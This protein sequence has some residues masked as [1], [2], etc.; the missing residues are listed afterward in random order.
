M[1][2]CLECLVFSHRGT[3]GAGAPPGARPTA[4]TFAPCANCG[5][6]A[7][8]HAA[9]RRPG[10]SI[11][12]QHLTRVSSRRRPGRRRPHPFPTPHPPSMF[13]RRRPCVGGSSSSSG[14]PV[15]RHP[16][17]PQPKPLPHHTALNPTPPFS[18][19]DHSRRLRR[20][21][22]ARARAPICRHCLL[23]W[24]VVSQATLRARGRHS[25]PNRYSRF[26]RVHLALPSP[27]LS[28]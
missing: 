28:M 11:I 26:I 27:P 9:A 8:M 5:S 25:E 10:P 7:R 21:A 6:D 22:R 24:R 1:H 18:P 4:P 3:H 20:A 2:V 23:H 19:F 13:G 17:C 16:A 14:A 15:G 12:L